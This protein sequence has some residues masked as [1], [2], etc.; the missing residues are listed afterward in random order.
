MRRRAA[1]CS[2]CRSAGAGVPGPSPTSC[3]V[4]GRT[5]TAGEAPPSTASCTRDGAAFHAQAWHGWFSSPPMHTQACK[6]MCSPMSAPGQLPVLHARPRK[7]A[8]RKARPHQRLGVGAAAGGAA[9]PDLQVGAGRHAC[10][11]CEGERWGWSVLPGTRCSATW[12]CSGRRHPMCPAM[13]PRHLSTRQPSRTCSRPASTGFTHGCVP[14]HVPRC[15]H[16][17]FCRKAAAQRQ[18]GGLA[19]GQPRKGG[20]TVAITQQ[21][22]SQPSQA[23]IQ[24]RCPPCLHQP[25]AA[26]QL[27]ALLV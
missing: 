7:V 27:G 13:P 15:Q 3:K 10:I 5:G 12:G 9:G 19:A 25:C 21:C 11:R 6:S 16:T 20:R 14:P 23:S 22:V 8:A 18:R 4:G 2:G 26:A 17:P 24:G 1:A